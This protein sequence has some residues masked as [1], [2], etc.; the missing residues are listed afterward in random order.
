MSL[1][2]KVQ[3]YI[4]NKQLLT[5][6]EKVIVGL[7]G[8]AD[9]MALLH[10]LL[11][12][13]YNCIAAHCNFHLRGEES[14]RDEDFAK[15]FCHKN[16]IEY[17]SVSFDTYAYMDEKSISLEMAA[18]E[19]RYNWFE[20]ISNK[21]KGSKIAIAHH[22]DDSV[23]TILINLIRG[24]GIRG[25]TGI[26]PENG[27]IIRP[28]LC[29]SRFEIL[30]YLKENNIPFVEDSTN[31]EDIYT[32]N[33]IRLKILPL[34]EEINPSVKQTIQQ[35]GEYLSEVEQ[36]YSTQISSIINEVFDGKN[37]N[38]EKLKQHQE[39]KTILFEIL[40]PYGFNS[41]NISRIFEAT[42]STSGKI[43]YAKNYRLIKD[44]EYFILEKQKSVKLSELY[45]I[46]EGIISIK[47]PVS[48]DIKT[49]SYD[50]NF[51]IAK[52]KNIIYVDKE[53][54]TFPLVIRKWKHGD[55]FIPFGMNGRKKIS[56]YFTDNKFSIPQKENT[57]LLCTSKDEI[58]WIVGERA[59]NRFKIT[60][61]T[62]DILQIELNRSF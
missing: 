35:T 44:R 3:E 23:E 40:H 55:S 42:D 8:G 51:S 5:N 17:Q 29:L 38:I 39:G 60:D 59:D 62:V 26:P 43:F 11:Q 53:K 14:G 4:E 47:E 1:L 9:S 18:R 19:L 37:I 50:N 6:N 34:L 22:R 24:S 61:R 58:I 45:T 49:L 10:I 41:D 36:I 13:G 7:S 54:L 15:A 12:L 28:L 48:I 25:L 56:D 31:N 57:W 32:R 33:K 20:E 16:N 52:D 30:N 2:K 21:Y 27:K 46:E